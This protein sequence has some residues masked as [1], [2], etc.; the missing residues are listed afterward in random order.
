MQSSSVSDLDNVADALRDD[1]YVVI[2]DVVPKDQLARFADALDAAYET[3]EK[4]KGGGSITGHLNC[5]PG[6]TA[7][8]AYDAISE[9]GIVATVHEIR[10]GRDN[11]VR[12]TLNYNLPGS[13]PQHYH[14][15]GLYIE[16]FVICN[17]AVID[18][19]VHNGAIDLLPGTNREFIPYWKF[20][21]KRTSRLS[22]QIEMAQG[23]VLLRKSN[24]WHRGMPN[25]SD[26]PRP[27]L[28]I[29]FGE[30]SAPQSDPFEGDVTFYPNWYNTSRLGVLRERTFV[31]APIS[32]SA[33]RFV[34]SLR[35]GRGYSSY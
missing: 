29:T 20:S 24:L 21:L 17:V 10:S 25:K 11:S 6:R 34:K 33:Y 13:V 9:R 3:A 18:T 1:G 5:F 12:A 26:A 27:M 32:Y 7:S 15:D 16:D 35:G 22:T 4:F 31:A 23:D 28:S 8:F 2:R 30:K 14:I 19:T